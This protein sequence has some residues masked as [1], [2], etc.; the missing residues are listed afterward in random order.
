MS[1]ISAALLQSDNP[2]PSIELPICRGRVGVDLLGRL[3]AANHYDHL[4]LRSH[5]GA[6]ALSVTG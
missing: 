1:S 3:L 4:P 5:G 6:D 2:S